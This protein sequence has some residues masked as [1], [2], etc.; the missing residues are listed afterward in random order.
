[1]SNLSSNKVF[2]CPNCNSKFDQGLKTPLT[3][4]CGHIICKDCINH[5]LKL[6]CPIDKKSFNNDIAS[7][8]IC[9]T[10][11]QHLP[12]SSAVFVCKCKSK[13]KIDFFCL[14][15]NEPLCA[16]CL[17]KHSGKP[18]KVVRFN[19][20]M[21]KM[22]GEVELVQ[23]HA[24]EKFKKI[25]EKASKL[26]EMKIALI[27]STK[28]EIQKLNEEI[29]KVIEGIIEYKNRME[30][31]II[32]FYNNQ[33]EIIEKF[34]IGLGEQNQKITGITRNIKIFLNKIND[35][36]VLVYDN[37]INEKNSI[38]YT[39]ENFLQNFSLLDLNILNN[40]EIQKIPKIHFPLKKSQNV[41]EFYEKIAICEFRNK[42]I[43]NKL[44]IDT[45]SHYLSDSTRDNTRKSHPSEEKKTKRCP[46]TRKNSEPSKP[47]RKFI[48][49]CKGEDKP[50]MLNL[51]DNY[52]EII[53]SL[54]NESAKKSMKN[55]SMI[56]RE[57][58]SYSH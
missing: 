47:N 32:E 36:K 24:I 1:M 45:T 14:F 13:G 15:E 27:D 9:H 56:K 22:I 52:K 8:P 41:S 34:K 48:V 29:N 33:S 57:K 42:N 38:F 4:P 37:V 7:L 53:N 31:R 54:Q 19:S 3:L 58:L 43:K 46:Y 35:N 39:W 10:L 18:H 6:V 5:S 17:E 30:E 40:T 55:E 50:I 12:P 23:S 49:D 25:N 20:P 11:M 2:L 21:D 26:S 28:E 16:E 51:N 44:N